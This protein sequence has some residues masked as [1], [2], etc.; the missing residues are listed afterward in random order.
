METEGLA[1]E[2]VNLGNPVEYT[3]LQFAEEILRITG[4][5]SEL[6]F[7]PLPQDDPT[8]RRPDISKARRLL[9][10]EPEIP[11]AEGLVPTL[12]YFEQILAESAVP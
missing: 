12:A 6:I 9:N 1:G 11:L 8:R 4:S 7:H 2:V 10:W 3:M 5:K